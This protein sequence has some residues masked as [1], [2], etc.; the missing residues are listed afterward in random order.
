MSDALDRAAKL[1]DEDRTRAL[2][3]HNS[4]KEPP[5]IINHVR[6]CLNCEIPVSL[7]RIECVNAVRCI[8]CQTFFELKEKQQRR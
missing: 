3:T 6:C 1:E 4:K 7:A 5:L 8:D 2:A